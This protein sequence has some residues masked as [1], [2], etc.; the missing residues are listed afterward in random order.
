MKDG[1][2][3]LNLVQAWNSHIYL[4]YKV[5]SPWPGGFPVHY[6]LSIQGLFHLILQFFSQFSVNN[7]IIVFSVLAPYEF[8]HDITCLLKKP[9][10]SP[11]R[12]LVV[13]R[14]W[15][16]LKI[17]GQS[18]QL[19]VHLHSLGSVASTPPDVVRSGMPLF[20]LPSMSVPPTL[21]V[22]VLASR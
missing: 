13:T 14:F 8:L 18:D 20:Y 17:L 22:P 19:L 1:Q 9:L 4:D 11:Y 7:T 21:P 2:V 5:T 3:E 12:Q 15:H 16:T 6:A 10:G